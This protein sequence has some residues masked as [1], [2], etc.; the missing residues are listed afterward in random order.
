[1]AA[2]THR[3]GCRI[4]LAM[5]AVIAGLPLIGGDTA[6][7]Q[8][9]QIHKLTAEDAAEGD[10]FGDS[11][12]V[13]DGTIVVGA[14]LDD[15]AG[16][17]AGSAYVFDAT[18]GQQLHKLTA[19]DA[20]EDDW[21][22]YCVCIS[23][24]TIVVGAPHD[25]YGTGAAYVFDAITG[26]QIHKLTASD[27]AEGDE[28]GQSISVSGNTIVVGVPFPNDGVGSGSAYVFDATTGKQLRKLTADDGEVCD[29]FGCSVSISGNTIV[30]GAVGDDDACPSD[31]EC[32]SGS[33]YVF[34]A[35]TGEQLFK[36]T[37]D[38]AAED[39]NFGISVSVSD[40]I[41]V[42]GAHE[43]DDECPSD[44]YCN[45]GSAYVFDGTTGEQLQK[46]WADDIAEGDHFGDS[47]SV[48][49]NTFAV[50]APYDDDAGSQSGSA[51]VFQIL[52]APCPADVTG[53]GVVDVLDLLAVLVAWG[54]SGV[55][56]DITGDGLVDTLDLLALLAAWGPC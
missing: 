8:W 1:M 37:A 28:F 7:G 21:F 50:G 38:D 4:P 26:Q 34:D 14:R 11:V 12:S 13:S 2:C 54:Q 32:N 53:D 56:E 44:P 23:A 19:D 49:G 43:D 6:S 39:D 35:A 9:D 27:G 16:S 52:D 41:I 22:G 55:P 17:Q 47:V 10:H 5:T 29:T 48:S 24:N 18:T 40:S 3:A 31:P 20:E 15:D 42:I 36:L 33:A 46:L 30:V 51:Y 45:S 25:D